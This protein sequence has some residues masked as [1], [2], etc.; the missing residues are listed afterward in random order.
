VGC[1]QIVE[2]FDLRI[3]DFDGSLT[4]DPDLAMG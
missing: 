4:L 3:E 1:D 2:G